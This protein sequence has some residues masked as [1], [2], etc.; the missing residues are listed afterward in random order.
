MS[1]STRNLGIALGKAST[2][3]EAL[4]WLARFHGSVVVVKYGG[5]AMLDPEVQRA[6]AADLVFLR[7]VGPAGCVHGGPQIRD[8]ESTRHQQRVPRFAGDHA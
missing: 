5:H 1:I 7:Y 2:L 4:P 6:F 8:A 3:V